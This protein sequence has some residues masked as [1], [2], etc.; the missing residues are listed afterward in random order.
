MVPR[1]ACE[2]FELQ[3]DLNTGIKFPRMMRSERGQALNNGHWLI[4]PV[5]L[6]T[7]FSL[8]RRSMVDRLTTSDP[9]EKVNEQV[10]SKPCVLRCTAVPRNEA[11][12]T[13]LLYEGINCIHFKNQWHDFD[14]NADTTFHFENALT[15]HG[16][17]HNPIKAVLI[18][19]LHKKVENV[20]LDFS[21]FEIL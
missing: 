7:D 9:P 15:G 16:I 20:S 11:L 5:S 21:S 1:I 10:S 17:T 4:R 12:A 8:Q 14:I 18:F 13:F 19:A 3:G 2:F 6:V